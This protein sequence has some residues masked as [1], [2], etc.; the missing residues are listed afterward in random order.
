MLL[1]SRTIL[2]DNTIWVISNTPNADL[3]KIKK[4]IES[5]KTVMLSGNIVKI[6]Q[7]LKEKPLVNFL[8]I[9]LSVMSVSDPNKEAAD[10]NKILV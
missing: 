4:A 9:R 2:E 7:I 6:V 5:Q 8:D 10:I 3:A 1:S